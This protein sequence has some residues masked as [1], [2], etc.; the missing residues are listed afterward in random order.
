MGVTNSKL[1]IGTEESFNDVYLSG[2]GIENVR[3][4]ML[5]GGA[6]HGGN[7]QLSCNRNKGNAE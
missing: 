5:Q 1:V 2:H 3:C 4:G 7:K 6:G